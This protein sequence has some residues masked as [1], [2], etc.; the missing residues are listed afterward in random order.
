M[1]NFL[2]EDICWGDSCCPDDSEYI[3]CF[4]YNGDSWVKRVEVSLNV[5]YILKDSST[6]NTV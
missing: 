1:V 2:E 5:K 4:Q 6:F 3:G